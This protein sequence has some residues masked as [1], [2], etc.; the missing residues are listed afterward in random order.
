TYQKLVD[1]ANTDDEMAGCYQRMAKL[2]ADALER[3]SDAVD[4]WNR[5]LDL[6][7]EDPLALGELA[8]L[9]EGAQRYEELAEI[10]E[11]QVH[12]VESEDDRVAVYQRLGRTYGTHLERERN[13]LDAW[14]TAVEIDPVNL[15]SLET[16]KGI[17]EHGQAWM[18]LNDI[19]HRLAA[20]GAERLGWERLRDIYA[21]IGTIQ[22]EYLMQT[23][24]SIA[25]WQQVLQIN[26]SDLEA[27]AALEQLFT[28]EARWNEAIT[29]LEQKSRVIEDEEER[30]DVL[31]QI[32][33]T[34]EDKLED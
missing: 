14:L 22:G 20:L 34:W 33:S 21:Q 24:D 12:V 1:V 29:V 19:L 32:A 16:L 17:Y 8:T 30:I 3:E 28:Q 18:E 4:L 13:A 26:Q 23:D 25:A 15:E 31:M 5:V 10:L 7:G 27:L 11:R 9:H 6:R 2:A